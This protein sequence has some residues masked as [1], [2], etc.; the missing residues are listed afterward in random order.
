MDMFLAVILAITYVLFIAYAVKGGNLFIGFF[1]M[2]ILWSLVGGANL[3]FILEEVLQKG[4][5]AYAPTAVLVIF[6]SWFGRVLVETGIA[7]TIIRRAVEL[8]GDKP[9]ITTV[10]LSLVVTL[11]F[12]ST[13]G[14]GAVIAIGV[15]ALPI[16]MSLGVPKKLA[17]SSFVMSV[18]AGMYLNQ[19]LF[20]QMQMIFKDIEYNNW[21]P[22]GATAMAVQFVVIVAMIF[23]NLRG[24]AQVRA[25]AAPADPSANRNVSFI[26]MFVPLV[27]VG[28]AILFGWKPVPCLFLGAIF[29]L[30]LTGNMWSLTRLS[31]IC[32]KTLQDGVSDVAT[33]LGLLFTL[34]M[35]NPAAQNAVPIIQRLVGGAIHINP[36]TIA[37]LVG[38]AAPLGLFRGP[39][40]VWGVGAA[41]AAIFTGILGMPSHI[42]LPMIYV[43]TITMAI[44][45]CP[46][47]SW[48]MWTVGYMKLE[49]GSFLK[50]GVPWGWLAVFANLMIA[51]LFFAR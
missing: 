4:A 37:L 48:N 43:P 13:F 14:V 36:W 26:A 10:L 32:Q 6:G 27:P 5:N 19:T 30:L 42:A 22:F 31:N 23:W 46:T 15:I 38:L 8:G 45:C 39:L 18:G 2:A 9:G 28:M 33:L 40:M 34:S 3:N 7:G 50:T 24:G 44:S 17:V 1:V 47:Q 35:F 49:V 51:M 29:A 20:A 12:T 41:T 25:W 11:I 21:V 16:L